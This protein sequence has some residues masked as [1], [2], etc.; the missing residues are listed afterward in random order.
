M[1][2]YYT[3]KDTKDI[4]E[5][6]DEV[7]EII[8]QIKGYRHRYLTKTQK[9]EDAE[10]EVVAM[11]DR[12]Q[13]ATKVIM[14]GG[15][16]EGLNLADIQRKIKSAEGR[17]EKVIERNKEDIETA[18]GLVRSLI[19]ALMDIAEVDI[20]TNYEGGWD[21]QSEP[22]QM[23]KTGEVGALRVPKIQE[24]PVGPLAPEAT[25]AIEDHESV[26]DEDEEGG[27]PYSFENT[28]L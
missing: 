14:E 9:V 25:E 10:K 19:D 16:I 12:L 21:H 11:K 22:V 15:D 8:K 28:S 27:D 17:R 18:E 6:S 23:T 20:P 13:S 7:F 24:A 3:V 26:S 1:S 4:I 5:K 2:E